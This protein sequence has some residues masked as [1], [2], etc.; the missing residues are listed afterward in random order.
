M[1]LLGGLPKISG[2]L[3]LPCDCSSLDSHPHLGRDCCHRVALSRNSGWSYPDVFP[4][5]KNFSS[6]LEL[7]DGLDLARELPG[8]VSPASSE[9]Q[10]PKDTSLSLPSASLSCSPLFPG[11][12]NPIPT[13]ML[14]SQR[15]V[16]GGSAFG[17]PGG[18][19][20]GPVVLDSS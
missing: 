12:P 20:P 15:C 14:P 18:P 10:I 16:F 7:R 13:L 6:L 19:F 17:F 11:S 9:G 2:L 1:R 3:F 5:S 4:N 8:C